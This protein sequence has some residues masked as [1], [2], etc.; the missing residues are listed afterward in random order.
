MKK[1]K[2]YQGFKLYTNKPN[3][4]SKGALYTKE[5]KIEANIPDNTRLIRVYLPSNYDFDNPN[6]RF[7][8]MYMMDG[9][10][11]FDHYTSFVGEWHVDET[12]EKY[13]KQNGKGL[14]VVGIDS[15]ESGED[16]T[17]EMLIESDYYEMELLK[18]E[19]SELN[20]KGSI[21]A[22]YIFDK[23]KPMIDET[24]YTKPD[25]ENT[26]VGGSSM[27]GLFAFY[28][29]AKYRSQVSFSLC[30]TPGFA[31][32]KKDNFINE[33]NKHIKSSEGY[34]KFF[35][36]V[37]GIGLEKIL[38]PLTTITVNHLSSVGFDEKQVRYIYDSSQTHNEEPWSFYY[39]VAIKW[40]GILE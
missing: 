23:L 24:F 38:E 32:Y 5:I 33:L 35:F 13:V 17:N 7:P 36:F 20:P 37:G 14:I 25:R 40:W 28:M 4:I 3:T 18:E 15:A 12:V 8:V 29:G 34:G 11:L 27:G 19:V 31:L 9:K 39:D 6:K 10:N 2:E 16:R 26:A 1:I 21:L 22:E 30:F